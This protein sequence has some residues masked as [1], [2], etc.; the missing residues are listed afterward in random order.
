MPSINQLQLFVEEDN[1]LKEILSLPASIREYF[2]RIIEDCGVSKNYGYSEDSQCDNSA[3]INNNNETNKEKF[4]TNIILDGE[5]NLN[6]LKM[7]NN[8][9]PLMS[10]GKNIIYS[11]KIELSIHG[12]VIKPYGIQKWNIE[13][14]E[15][16]DAKLKDNLL[17]S[18]FS[19]IKEFCNISIDT[20]QSIIDISIDKQN[21][22]IAIK[23]HSEDSSTTIPFFSVRMQLRKKCKGLRK[24][25]TKQAQILTEEQKNSP[26][27]VEM[28][29]KTPSEE[30]K[31]DPLKSQR[32]IKKKSVESPTL[33]KEIPEEIGVKCFEEITVSL[34]TYVSHKPP[35]T[36]KIIHND[37]QHLIDHKINIAIGL[38][39]RFIGM[40]FK[41]KDNTFD[42]ENITKLGKIFGLKLQK[43]FI[44]A[45][46]FKSRESAQPYKE[47]LLKY[48]FSL[49]NDENNIKVVKVSPGVN[50]K[51]TPFKFYTCKQNNAI[52]V[53]GILKQ[54]WWWTYTDKN[55]E[56]L[57]LLW[58][59]WCKRK[60]ISELPCSKPEECD[61]FNPKS[62]K[63]PTWEK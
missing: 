50:A 28:E 32:K 4:S 26:C 40:T 37:Y 22:H 12:Q 20:L 14:N 15:A 38:I 58:T 39:N 25:I 41:N 47:K 1:N 44:N 55:D 48:L 10:Q 8:V 61:L 13:K 7:L 33:C 52:M 60:F 56:N 23:K 57:N 36:I 30:T 62:A 31:M 59:Q 45:Q 46:A 49:I 11:D 35:T 19:L 6:Q 42:I 3:S 2:E 51:P 34:R 24:K 5:D 18:L 63:M 54:R 27:A 16:E 17:K 43:K 21:K 9:E 53:R 29:N